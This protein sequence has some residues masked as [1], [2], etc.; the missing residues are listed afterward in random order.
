[1][2]QVHMERHRLTHEERAQPICRLRCP[3]LP[4]APGGPWF[5]D[6]GEQTVS[7][8]VEEVVFVPHVAIEAH[9]RYSEFARQAPDRHLFGATLAHGLS[10]GANHLLA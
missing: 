1:M 2:T 4:V 10:R 3:L 7:D 8:L 6:L 9:G 5:P